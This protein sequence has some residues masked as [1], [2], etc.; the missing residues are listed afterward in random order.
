ME[1]KKLLE[2]ETKLLNKAKRIFEKNYANYNE[3]DKDKYIYDE[4]NKVLGEWKEY[5][6]KIKSFNL[7]LDEYTN[8]KG[9]IIVDDE[10]KPKSIGKTKNGKQQYEICEGN[11]LCYFLET[12]SISWGSSRPGNNYQY[13]VAKIDK[14][15]NKKIEEDNKTIDYEYIILTSEKNKNLKIKEAIKWSKKEAEET[16]KKSILP[17]LKVLVESNFDFKE[18]NLKTFLE[19]EKIT[20]TN[21]DSKKKEYE[22]LIYE[23][24]DHPTAYDIYKYYPAKQVL[25]KIIVLRSFDD[26]NKSNSNFKYKLLPIYKDEFFEWAWTELLGEDSKKINNLETIEKNYIVTNKLKDKFDMSK[27]KDER[28]KVL[29]LYKCVH[30]MYLNKDFL[31]NELNVIFHGA[32][33]TGK[34]YAVM[35]GL[36]NLGIDEDHICKIQCHMNYNYE[37]FIE[38]IKPTSVT[39]AGQMKLELISGQFKSFCLKAK[40][41]L[42]N[43]EDGSGQDD[44]YFICDEINRTNVSEMFGETLAMIEKSYRDD[45]NSNNRNELLVSTPLSNVIK[46]KIE[47]LYSSN[48][49]D[50]CKSFIDKNVYELIYKNGDT[51][52]YY[53]NVGIDE[54]FEEWSQCKPADA[55]FNN[56]KIMFGIPKNLRFIGMMNDVDKSI[57]SFD[58]ALRRRFKWIRK[59]FDTEV[60]YNELYGFEESDSYIE[61]CKALNKFIS[62]ELVMGKAYEFGH[63]YFLKIKDMT[64]D[65]KISKT[66]KRRLFENY[67]EPILKEYLRSFHDEN[68]IDD[69]VKECRNKFG[70]GDKNAN[71][72]DD[73]V[74]D[75]ER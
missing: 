15:S 70:L 46:A 69:K 22:Y 68:E 2:N 72:E 75:I 40:K 51:I 9:S 67:L 64:N 5:Y 54:M 4:R 63:S 18:N 50:E 66:N 39:E 17:M 10:N 48:N 49:I 30:G 11:Y 36:K 24:K 55:L 35:E 73:E 34:T 27:I 19:S 58:L 62:E 42:K 20:L 59:D 60:L 65:K 3:Q 57:D 16:Y 26:Q 71:N 37:D 32:P 28:S 47:E 23:D 45:L 29:A 41:T 8:C 43:N 61:S 38:G 25:D 33:G 52:K 74:I 6:N 12:K 13:V 56:M 44:F 14:K 1:E 53:T 7:S 31:D 21:K